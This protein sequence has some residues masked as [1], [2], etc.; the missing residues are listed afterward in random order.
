[1]VVL[2]GAPRPTLLLNLESLFRVSLECLGGLGGGA[3]DPV[4]G[5]RGCFGPEV[6]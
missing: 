3:A 4:F 1:M 2:R 5:F 6:F